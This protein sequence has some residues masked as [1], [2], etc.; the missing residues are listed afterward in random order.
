MKKSE[1]ETFR[2]GEKRE[3]EWSDIEPNQKNDEQ[4]ERIH[5]MLQFENDE[6]QKVQQISVE[7]FIAQIWTSTLQ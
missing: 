4:M 7:I 5:E 3:R 6:I 1:R 2:K